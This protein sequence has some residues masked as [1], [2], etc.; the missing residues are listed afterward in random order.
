M[1]KHTEIRRRWECLKEM[2]KI[3]NTDKFVI[4]I[5]ETSLVAMIGASSSGKTTFARKHFLP[6]EV[7]SSDVYRGM[8]CDDEGSQ[9]ASKDAFEVLFH[10]VDKR[11]NRMKLAVVDATNI[12]QDARRQILD[13]ARKQNISAGAIVLNLPEQ[14]IQERN[15]NREDHSLPARVIKRHCNDVKRSLKG[16]KREGFRH[17]YVINS[18]EQLENVEIVRTKLWC[19]KKDEHGPFDIIGD[20]HGCAKELEMLLEK[21]GY[22][23]GE[24]GCAMSI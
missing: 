8:V 23:K 5:P 3:N 22:I 13:M 1:T 15:A 18:L 11:L 10:V 7:L 9:A 20:V 6:T 17:V 12:Q 14:V 24:N 4:E 21:L 19:D 2:D 16:L